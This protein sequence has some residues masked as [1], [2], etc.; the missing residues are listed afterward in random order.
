[1]E[2]I[3]FIDL[4]A[5]RHCIGE[6]IDAAIARVLA[7]GAFIMGPEIR[8]LE[9]GLSTFCGARHAI[10]C[11]SGTD[12]LLLGLMAKGVGSG[13][14]VLVP[15]FTFAASAEAVAL[16]GATPVFMD[17]A[18]DTFVVTPKTVEAGLTVARTHG[19][20]PVGL[21]AVGLFGQPT[22]FDALAPLAERH[23]FWLMD[24][25]AQSFGSRLRDRRT[26]TLAE[27][28]AT[29]FFPAKPLGCYGDGGAVF[30]DD[31]ELAARM[32]SLRVHGQGTDKYDNTRIGLNAR[33]D[34]LQAAI[35]IEKLA[36]YEDEIAARQTVAQRYT[37]GLGD[38]VTVPA[39]ADG[40]QSVWAQYTIQVEAERRSAIATHLAEQGIPT[41]IYYPRPLH[42]QTAYA[43]FPTDP[44]GLPVAE[45]LSRRVLSLPMHPYLSMATQDRIMAAVRHSAACG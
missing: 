3:A 43:N 10:S 37:D 35:L 6:R 26:G 33:M 20:R 23:G 42:Q 25:A 44:A 1:M 9:A 38:A 28:T 16:L 2:K 41:A 13:D 12:A 24:D 36:I 15:T 7:H 5:Q 19:L 8:T 40:A 32:R 14:A 21:I 45:A 39:V 18:A 4:A 31:D 22:D 29:S 11:S 27:I 30:T 17:V 34:T